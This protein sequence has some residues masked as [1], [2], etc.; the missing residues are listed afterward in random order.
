MSPSVESCAPPIP[1]RVLTD[2]RA[3]RGA[4]RALEAGGCPRVDQRAERT[5]E[6]APA[7]VDGGTDQS[8][9]GSLLGES[10]SVYP[11]MRLKCPMGCQE[12]E[13]YERDVRAMRRRSKRTEASLALAGLG[14]VLVLPVS[15]LAH[16][17]SRRRLSRYFVLFGLGRVSI[18]EEVACRS[19]AACVMRYRCVRPH[20]CSLALL[21]G[22]GLVAERGLRPVLRHPDW[23][24]QRRALPS[25]SLSPSGETESWAEFHLDMI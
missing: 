6:W 4:L 9:H 1:R 8:R 23:E 5:G 25:G 14:V 24:R 20:R 12:W 15:A 17:R 22:H 13:A 18:C 2:R 7:S 11:W 21:G 16:C 3:V 10:R 19:R